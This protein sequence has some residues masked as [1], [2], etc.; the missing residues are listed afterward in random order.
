MYV[1]SFKKASLC[2]FLCMTISIGAYTQ[3]DHYEALFQANETFTYLSVR[4]A[5]TDQANEGWRNT[6]FDDS[7]SLQPTHH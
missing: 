2:F 5:A 4:N 7:A 1:I 3:A 6:D